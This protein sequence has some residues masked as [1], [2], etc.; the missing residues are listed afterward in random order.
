[1]AGP[2][3]DLVKDGESREP[4]AVIWRVRLFRDIHHGGPIPPCLRQSGASA[5]QAAEG[6]C[7]S[8]ARE[9]VA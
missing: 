2:G 7:L 6:P 4:S 3:F 1:M 5:R 9:F 8:T